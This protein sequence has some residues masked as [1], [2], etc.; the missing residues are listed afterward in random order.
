MRTRRARRN[1]LFYQYRRQPIRSRCPRRFG[2]VEV[3]NGRP[4]GSVGSNPPR[5]VLG[6]LILCGRYDGRLVALDSSSG[7]LNWSF[8]TDGPVDSSPLVAEGTVFFGSQAGF[9]YALD[10]QTGEE[11]WRYEAR[12][13]IYSLS[14]NVAGDGVFLKRGRES[15]CGRRRVRPRTLDIQKPQ[16]VPLVSSRFS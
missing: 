12:W 1:R 15:A 5:P 2:Q 11:K 14:G 16:I 4:L 6:E 13:P 7:Q 8:E 3:Q 10:A 9:L